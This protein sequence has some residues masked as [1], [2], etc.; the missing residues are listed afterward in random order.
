M[1]LWLF[2]VAGLVWLMVLVGGVTRLTGSGLSITEWAPILGA[3]PPLN[4]ADWAAAFAK[5]REIPQYRLMNAGMTLA[6]FR[7][8]YGW[9]WTHRLLGRLIG[10]AYAV[11]MVVFLATGAIRRAELPRFLAL[12]VLGGLQ[13]VIGWWMVASGLVDR[14]SVAPLRLAVH[15][16]LAAMIFAALLWTALT[17]A[18][19]GRPSR[20]MSRRRRL[21]A[22]VVLAWVFVQIFLGALVAG[23]DAGLVYNTW[24]M[25]GEHFVPPE[26]MAYD[27]WWVNLFENHATVQF[28]HRMG[29]YLLF[30]LA[31]AQFV[32]IVV[33]G[34]T[35]T[36]RVSAFALGFMAA[37]QILVGIATL[38]LQV[39]LSLAI[40]HQGVAML[41]LVAAVTHAV[42]VFS[43]GRVVA[44]LSHAADRL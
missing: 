23:N 18:E 41:V 8:I 26:L 2:A 36:A 44:G 29:A 42:S 43:P 16:T 9:E 21:A 22:A 37:F 11:P 17:L 24:P 15:L 25:M 14:V 30:A 1:R 38:L 10:V 4:D 27:P 3:L 12:L 13:G 32:S 35:A 5:Y 33:S 20:P 34:R 39:P 31:L 19:A 6:D 7:F 40:V 28:L